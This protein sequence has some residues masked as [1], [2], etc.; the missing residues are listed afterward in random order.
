[1]RWHRIMNK[2]PYTCLSQMTLEFIAAWMAHNEQMPN[3]INIRWHKWERQF[4][5]SLQLVQI[6]MGDG[7]PPGIPLIE[8]CQLYPQKGGLKLV[9]ARGCSNALMIIL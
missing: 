1:M 9:K 3:R 7:L 5:Q 2:S 4:R 8:F 6:M